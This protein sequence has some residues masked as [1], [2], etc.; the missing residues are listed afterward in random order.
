MLL[1]FNTFKTT[2][3]ML[4]GLLVMAS[5][6]CGGGGPPGK[7]SGSA[8]VTVTFGGQPVTE[9]L[10]SLQNKTGD[11]G[12]APLDSKGMATIA[13]VVKGDYVVTVTPPVVGFA[14]PDP[15]KPKLT[16]KEYP[17]IPPKFRS[18][19]SS[20]LKA[21]IKVGTNELKFDLQQ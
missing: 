1:R 16:P 3:H 12:G 11:G 19:D 15:G 13:N 21:E 4:L 2:A 20:P 9:G 7:P 8:T 18:T 10:V 17:N 5:A 6:G 14:A